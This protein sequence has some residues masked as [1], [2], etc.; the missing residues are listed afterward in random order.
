M[1]HKQIMKT[2]PFGKCELPIEVFNT[3][4]IVKTKIRQILGRVGFLMLRDGTLEVKGRAV[5]N[6]ATSEVKEILDDRE[7]AL[8]LPPF[9]KPDFF[10]SF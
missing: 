3:E 5:P 2:T 8:L 6:L 9:D 7:N 10:A 4:R 1:I